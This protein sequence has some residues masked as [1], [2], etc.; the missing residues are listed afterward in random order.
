[1]S[2]TLKLDPSLGSRIPAARQIVGLRNRLVHAYREVDPD[3]LWDIVESDLG[4][5]EREV[6]RLLDDLGR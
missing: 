5:L 6:G 2:C 3:A 1:M 4:P